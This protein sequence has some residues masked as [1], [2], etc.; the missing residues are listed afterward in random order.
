MASTTAELDFALQSV[1]DTHKK[2]TTR[3]GE[4]IDNLKNG[5]A[6]AS[7]I[8]AL[9]GDSYE[10]C[11]AL[12]AE[13]GEA[14]V[15]RLAGSARALEGTA[16]AVSSTISRIKAGEKAAGAA[17]AED[18]AAL[19]AEFVGPD[20][21]TVAAQ[22]GGTKEFKAYRDAMKAAGV[23]RYLAAK[24]ADGDDELE[25]VS[26]TL[27]VYCP[28]TKKVFEEPMR[29][30]NCKHIFSKEGVMNLFTQRKAGANT[31]MK[32]PVSGCPVS[33][34]RDQLE[35]DEET[36]KRVQQHLKQSKK[37]KLPADEPAFT[38]ID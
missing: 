31:A 19:Q 37:R 16:R 33:F 11:E 22:P 10:R 32:C 3:L 13:P 35:P 15:L 27:T 9:A 30:P 23:K 7:K 2:V 21:K 25:V 26:A 34:K 24:D 4:I 18:M 1:K 6:L 28:I 36:A 14:I 20:K 29:N 12:I 38:Q 5:V 8:E 17:I